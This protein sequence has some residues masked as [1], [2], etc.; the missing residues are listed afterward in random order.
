MTRHEFLEECLTGN[1]NLVFVME[2]RLE[3]GDKLEEYD[4]QRE[5]GKKTEAG[6]YFIIGEHQSCW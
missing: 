1:M 3:E 2:L 5:D 6:S 4:F